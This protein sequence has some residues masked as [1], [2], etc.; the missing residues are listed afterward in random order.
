[1]RTLQTIAVLALMPIALLAQD[2]G[3]ATPPKNSAGLPSQTRVDVN[4]LSPSAQADYYKA[5]A[6]KLSSELT[7]TTQERDYWKDQFFRLANPQQ[8]Q[9]DQQATSIWLK[10]QSAVQG[11]L[12]EAQK[13]LDNAKIADAVER[14]RQS[15]KQS[16]EKK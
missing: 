10:E 12:A 13:A 16:T 15:I 3:N 14:T 6:I 4:A 2:K 7:N 11:Q 5:M 8:A 9:K 1:M